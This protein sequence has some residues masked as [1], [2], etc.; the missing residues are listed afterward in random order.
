MEPINYG[1]SSGSRRNTMRKRLLGVVVLGLLVAAVGMGCS[2]KK[3]TPVGGA[4][5]AGLGEEGL[6]GGG[7]LDRYKQG[8]LGTGDQGP[9]K[10]V[11]FPFD[12]YE[13]D[14]QARTILR[15]NGNWLRDHASAKAEIEGHCD[16]RGTVEYNLALGAKRAHSVKDY[17]VA[18]GVSADRLTTISYGEE[19]PLCQEHNESC[20]QTNRRVHAVVLGE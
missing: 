20:W 17:L 13:L 9:L 12:S 16:E 5:G 14:D 18:L 10:D 3:P 8:A 2:A 4:P 11:H 6:A 7:S 1:L 15:D 19:L